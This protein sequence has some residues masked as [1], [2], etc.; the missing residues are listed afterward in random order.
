MMYAISLLSRF[1]AKKK[2]LKRLDRVCDAMVVCEIKAKP[3][4]VDVDAKLDSS[5]TSM[6]VRRTPS[7]SRRR[8]LSL[9]RTATEVALLLELPQLECYCCMTSLRFD[10]QVH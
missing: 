1:I 2:D 5:S 4:P 6:K 3:Q 9:W 7:S 8:Q 10:C